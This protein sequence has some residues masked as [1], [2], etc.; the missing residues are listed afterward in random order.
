MSPETLRQVADLLKSAPAAG[1][2][3][4]GYLDLIGD[5]Q[6][7]SEF[8]ERIFR[9]PP[10]SAIYENWWRPSLARLAKGALGPSMSDEH[11]IARLLLALTPGDTVLD[12]ACGT[13][14][15]TRDFA[16]AVGDSGLVVGLDPSEPMLKRAVTATREAGFADRV[17]YVRSGADEVPFNESSFNAVCCFAAL[18]LFPKPRETLSQMC[19]LLSPGGR[20][21][22][23][24]TVRGRT[25]G[26]RKAEQLVA[27]RSGVYMF[28]EDEIRKV[29]VEK[30]F[31]EIRQRISGFTQFIGARR[32]E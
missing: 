21:A 31:E 7:P 14:R 1:F 12:V 25:K 4:D 11:E 19:G 15:F 5:S 13:G 32:A 10:L 30:G 16:D 28:E 23:F 9:F 6:R 18:H 26:L 3:H 24:T 27:E 17:A 8:R 20:I 22:L 29:L 2:H